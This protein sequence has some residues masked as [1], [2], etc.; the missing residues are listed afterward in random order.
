MAFPQKVALMLVKH[1]ASKEKPP[2]GARG[3]EGN[4]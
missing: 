2:R 1:S 3:G 4:M